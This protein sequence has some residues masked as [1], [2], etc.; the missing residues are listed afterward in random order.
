M[1]WAGDPFGDRAASPSCAFLPPRSPTFP[2]ILEV[3]MGNRNRSG[4]RTATSKRLFKEYAPF[5]LLVLMGPFARALFSRTLLSWPILC[6]SGQ[7]LSTFKG[8]WKP[9][10]VENFWVPILGPL[11]RTNFWLALC[12]LPNRVRSEKLQNEGSPNSSNF[13]PN[14]APNV[15]P[16]KLANGYFANGY[17]ENL[18]KVPRRPLL[19]ERNWGKRLDPSGKNIQPSNSPK[20]CVSLT[21][22][23]SKYPFTKYPFASLPAPN[24]P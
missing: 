22:W 14:F 12:G 1:F 11:A 13:V 5:I 20:M 2:T 21:N 4:G 9:H 8:S 19:R 16:Q 3:W 15:A 23:N 24:F 10:L 6:H 17:F 7:I 18:W